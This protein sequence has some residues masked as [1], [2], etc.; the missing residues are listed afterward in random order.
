MEKRQVVD[1]ILRDNILKLTMK[2]REEIQV[3]ES[4]IT[5]TIKLSRRELCTASMPVVLLSD[6]FDVFTLDQCEKLF[7]F[8]ENNV[9]IWKED[10][11]FGACKNNLL[12]MC[13]DLL[14]RLSRSQNTVFRG[15]ILLFLAK[16]FPFSERSGMFSY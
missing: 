10:L 12:R 13:N 2:S 9:S 3:L 15:R 4:F 1:Q 14:R 16:F 8:V 11:F 6:I 7:T 5:H